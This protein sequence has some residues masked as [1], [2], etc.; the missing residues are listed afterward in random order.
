M[1]R[2]VLI[3]R[4]RYRI[5]LSLRFFRLLGALVLEVFA[6]VAEGS[7]GLHVLTSLGRSTCKSDS[8]FPPAFLRSCL[9][10]SSYMMVSLL[11]LRQTAQSLRQAVHVDAGS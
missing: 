1:T 8:Q 4:W 7:G 9:V 11:Y 6:E 2:A 5:R 3:I 10:N